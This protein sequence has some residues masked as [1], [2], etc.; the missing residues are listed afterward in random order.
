[1]QLFLQ[2]NP[3]YQNEQATTSSIGETL[4]DDDE[5][6]ASPESQSMDRLSSDRY[7]ASDNYTAQC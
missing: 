4:V 5:S 6:V 2:G 7:A 1:M 3:A